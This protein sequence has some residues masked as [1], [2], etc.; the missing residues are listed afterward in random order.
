MRKDILLLKSGGWIFSNS[1][2][3]KKSGVLAI[4][5]KILSLFLGLIW[6]IS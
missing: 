2:C 3:L 6:S 5:K 4:G 1:G